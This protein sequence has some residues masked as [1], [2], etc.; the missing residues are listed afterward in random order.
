MAVYILDNSLKVEIYYECIDCEYPDN[1]S[2]RVTE[3]CPEDE[4]L[5]RADQVNLFLTPLEA[6]KLAFAL[7]SAAEHSHDATNPSDD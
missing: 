2:V 4:K 3:D 5:F 1:I 6:R 7:L